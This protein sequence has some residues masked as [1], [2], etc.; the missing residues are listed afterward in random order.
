[1]SIYLLLNTEHIKYYQAIRELSATHTGKLVPVLNLDGTKALIQVKRGQTRPD[2]M[3]TTR[4]LVIDRGDA[5]FARETL[6]V[7]LEWQRSEEEIRSNDEDDRDHIDYLEGR[8]T[9]RQYK[10]RLSARRTRRLSRET[11]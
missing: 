5:R 10:I 11:Q 2:W 6:S 8:T 9:E 4:G 3:S 1:M 7:S